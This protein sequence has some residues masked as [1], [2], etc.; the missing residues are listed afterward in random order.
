MNDR[1]RILILVTLAERGGAQTYL[2]ALVPALVT[3]FDVTVAS[4]G[5]GPLGDAMRAVGA[6]YVA[7]RHVRRPIAPRDALGLW[8]LYRLC[9]RLRPDIVHANSSKAGVVGR[10]AAALARVPVR[11]F[12][13]HGWAFKAATGMGSRIYL[14]CDRAMRGLTTAI[15]CVSET[16]RAAGLAAKTCTEKRT[17]VVY[18]AVD[19]DAVTVREHREQRPVEVVSVG[20]LAYPKDFVTL[21][22][23]CSR[24]EPGLARL[25]I[26][27]DGGDR[28]AVEEAIAE[29]GLEGVLM[30]GERDDVLDHLAVS[31]V[32]VLSSLSEGLPMS[33]LEAMAAGL[34]LVLTRVGGM[35]ELVAEGDN[36]RLVPPGDPAAL[37][38]AIDALARDV[39]LRRAYGAAS[40]KR[41]EETFALRRFQEEHV[42]LYER[43]LAGHPPRAVPA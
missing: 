2:R 42:R 26:V 24:L 25:T 30:L 36:G 16:E 28:G 15:V 32:F 6:D 33:V 18:N 17:V 31:D 12:T 10:L 27:G 37:A 4:Y 20:R 34:P 21:V 9:R 39:A 35:P 3:R 5:P 7:L 13:V 14:G 11:V 1:P 40:R 41:V 8:E 22:R 38:E 19:V 23:A 29:T 43:L